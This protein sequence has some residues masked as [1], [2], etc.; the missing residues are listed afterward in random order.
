[1]FCG[2]CGCERSDT[3]FCSQCGYEH[4][5]S[6]LSTTTNPD[7]QFLGATTSPLLSFST[8][9]LLIC[10]A[11]SRSSIT[12]QVRD[13]KQKTTLQDWASKKDVLP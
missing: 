1:M 3:K 10:T 12:A 8:Q 9:P 4:P 11:S 13:A 2:Q 6:T 5:P 7:V